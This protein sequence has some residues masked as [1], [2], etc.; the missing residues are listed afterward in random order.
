[1][2]FMHEKQR[3]GRRLLA[4][5]LGGAL[6]VL[7]G[8][9]AIR[10]GSSA[11]HAVAADLQ[12]PSSSS[13]L[14]VD[15]LLACIAPL[16][17]WLAVA[18]AAAGWDIARTLRSRPRSAQRGGLQERRPADA[19]DNT[20]RRRMA[21]V[22][23]ALTGAGA[24][25]TL[26][27]TTA[28]ASPL[29]P[30]TTQSAPV[31]SAMDVPVPATPAPTTTP[32]TTTPTTAPPSDIPE[33]GW[34]TPAPSPTSQ[35]CAVGARLIAGCPS[36]D[37]SAQVVVH[38]GDSLW[39]LISRHLHTHEPAVIAAAVPQWYAANKA[40]IGADPDIL[41]VGQRLHVPD[42]APLTFAPVTSETEHTNQG[43]R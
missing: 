39:S 29:L 16:L 11:V 15:L 3:T 4:I 8:T 37:D 40:V 28:S 35:R 31:I 17:A 5:A 7:A 30:G 14:F 22:L 33:P 9:T 43:E 34:V 13:K 1:M 19:R 6:A 42:T 25:G 10:A 36:R 2:F 21:A 38:R 18:S 41:H 24:L 12:G 27:S 26:P 23:L 32:K 20:G